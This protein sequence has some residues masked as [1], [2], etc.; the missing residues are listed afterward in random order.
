MAHGRIAS[1]AFGLRSL[2]VRLSL[3]V[4]GIV[5]CAVMATAV[6][7]AARAFQSDVDMRRDLLTGIAS[8]YAAALSDPV[9]SEDRPATR[10]VLRGISS[11]PG[12]VQADVVA[13]NGARLA[14]MGSGTLLIGRDG[15]PDSMGLWQLWSAKTLRM[16][17]EII[18]G[19]IAVGRLGLTQDISDLRA[20]V[21]ARLQITALSAAAAVLVAVFFAQ[22]FIA[23]MTAP[24]RRLTRHMA[25]FGAGE[26]HDFDLAGVGGD[27]TGV[28]ARTYNSMVASIRDRDARIARH[29]E[30]LEDTVEARTKDLSHARDEAEAANAAKSDFLA[31][32]SHEIRTPMN[33]IMVMAEMLSAANL[34]ARHRRYADIISRSGKGLLTIINDILDLSK[35]EAGKLD[36]EAAAVRIDDLVCDLASLYWERAREKGLALTTHVDASVPEE[37]ITDPTRLN[38]VLSNLVNNAL[39]FTDAGGVSLRVGPAPCG[40]NGEA[41]LAIQVADTGIGIAPDRLEHVFDAFSQADQTTTRRFGGTGLGLAVCKR[42]TRALGGE[43]SVRSREGRGSVFQVVIPA[44]IAAAAPGKLSAPL[45]VEVSLPEPRVRNSVIRAL[46]AAGAHVVDHGGAVCLATSSSLPQAPGVP[47]ALLCEVGD[48][49]SDSLLR[50]GK[51]HDLLPNPFTRQDVSGLLSRSMNGTLRGVSALDDPAAQV[52]RPSF[53]GL[54]VLA[55]DDNP[56]NREVLREA[57]GTLDVDVDF[58]EDGKEAVRMARDAAYGLVFMDGAM[59]VMDGFDAARTI[60]ADERARGAPRCPI[61]AL[62]AKVV[63]MDQDSWIDAGADGYVTKPFTIERLSEVLAEHTGRSQA[64]TPCDGRS[65]GAGKGLELTPAMALFDADTLAQFEM[66]KRPGEDDL[67]AR[68]WRLFLQQAP[69]AFMALEALIAGAA[70]GAKVSSHAHGLKSMA[71]SAGAARFANACGAVETLASLGGDEAQ[72]KQALL[73]SGAALMDTAS[74]MARLLA[75][76]Q[77][78]AAA[79]LEAG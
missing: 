46:E 22:W 62:T 23:R 25:A 70:P 32:M 71:L 64:V 15:D 77:G 3:M 21:L 75:D 49:R 50:L 14:D 17:V 24:L 4:A 65:D 36:L 43:I 57:L 2:R 53:A 58:A 45:A 11:V 9:A 7:S 6:F 54:R 26:T 55:A 19:G 59:P 20:A 72:I 28:L 52:P 30:T 76:E 42:L 5:V 39:K 13:A 56:V 16:D 69:P 68:I 41:C 8:A 35:I 29:M 67:R 27:E 73:Q 60:R 78:A 79:R 37:I 31:T 66:L 18:D 61:V 38:Q 74:A 48:V 63:G 33:G 44:Q 47:V 40:A 1:T 51:A 10:E 34:T 12:L